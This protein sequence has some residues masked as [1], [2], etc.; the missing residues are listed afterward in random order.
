MEDML[1]LAPDFSLLRDMPAS[2]MILDRELNFVAASDLY[3]QTVGMRI[4]D[5]MGRM[6][7]DVFPEDPERREPLERSMRLALAGE[8]NAIERLAYAIPDPQDKSRTTEAWWRCRHNPIAD[9]TGRVTHVVQITENVTDLVRAEEQRNAIAHELQ[10][11]VSNLLSLV[12]VIA[13]RT[14][15]GAE[16]LPSF[17][18]R[19]DARL[20]SMARTHAHLIG[21]NWD[22]MS[23]RDVVALQLQHGQEELADQIA[24]GGPDILLGSSEAQM[25]SM[26]IHEL[27]TNSMKYGALKDRVGRLEVAW[28]SDAERGFA[29]RWIESGMTAVVPTEHKGFGS[30][31]LDL[32]VP[33]QLGGAARREFTPDGLHYEITVGNPTL[34]T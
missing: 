16:T 20:Q 19:F 23:V 24:V 12:Q 3:L 32:I 28:T 34:P 10:H 26:A 7:F 25:L 30:M 17:L 14:A 5:L 8:G 9:A 15:A 31:I 6:V 11:R 21:R 1:D 22:R 33:T 18:E 2:I 27:T 29:F 4:E 13:R